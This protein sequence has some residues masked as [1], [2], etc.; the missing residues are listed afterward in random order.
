[1]SLARIAFTVERLMHTCQVPEGM[2]RVQAEKEAVEFLFQGKNKT[3]AVIY[4]QGKI[5][6]QINKR[7]VK[8]FAV[9]TQFEYAVWTDGRKLSALDSQAFGENGL[10]VMVGLAILGLS[11]VSYSSR[12]GFD[13]SVNSNNNNNNNNNNNG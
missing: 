9:N 12:S 6:C 3:H 13:I 4:H 1:M 8:S 11:E 7:T 10:Y 2:P 5:L